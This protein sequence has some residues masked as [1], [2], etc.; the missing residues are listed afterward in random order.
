MEKLKFAQEGHMHQGDTQ[1]FKLTE[2][3]K[4]LKKIE[5]QFV[6]ASERSGSFHGLFGN[7]DMYE[8]EE[9]FI[10]DVKDKCILNHSL[11]QFIEG[12]S[13]DQVKELPKKDHRA[14]EFLTP[15][16]YYVGIQQR[17]DPLKGKKEKVRD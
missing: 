4:N 10:V 1:W 17:F 6:A 9:G 14:T 8:I 3:P 12:I 13:M 15:G 2:L 16:I 5:K 7:Y 11:K